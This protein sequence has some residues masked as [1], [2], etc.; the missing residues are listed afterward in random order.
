M[1]PSLSSAASWSST[2]LRSRS[3]FWATSGSCQK[4]GCEDFC[5]NAARRLLFSEASKIAPHKLDSFLQFVVAMFQ[6]FENH[7]LSL[8]LP[9]LS[10]RKQKNCSSHYAQPPHPPAP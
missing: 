5:S 3:T 10:A 2:C 4:L 6:I 9:A 7:S 1:R 8:L